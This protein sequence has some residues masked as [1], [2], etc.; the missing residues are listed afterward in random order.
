MVSDQ[1]SDSAYIGAL[2]LARHGDTGRAVP[3]LVDNLAR[4][5][6]AR[7]LFTGLIY[8]AAHGGDA[9]HIRGLFQ[10]MTR[11]AENNRDR[12]TTEERTRLDG[13]LKSG[14]GWKRR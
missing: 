2:F 1:Q 3:I 13:L 5:P 4:N 8:A 14:T 6:E 7:R 11:Y 9:G 12:Y 10:E